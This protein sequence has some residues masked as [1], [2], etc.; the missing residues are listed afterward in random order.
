[1][2]HDSFVYDLYDLYGF[3]LSNGNEGR[4]LQKAID[5]TVIAHYGNKESNGL[6]G[7]SFFF[8]LNNSESKQYSVQTYKEIAAHGYLNNYY[9]FLVSYVKNV[10]GI[11]G[12]SLPPLTKKVLGAEN[13][14]NEP[15][16]VVTKNVPVSNAIQLAK[17]G[18][19]FEVSLDS[20]L[21]NSFVRSYYLILRKASQNIYYLVEQGH[22]L[23]LSEKGVLSVTLED[24][25][26]VISGE[27]GKTQILP[28]VESE[29][30]Q[31][32]L[33]GGTRLLRRR[34]S[35]VKLLT[36]RIIHNTD[37]PSGFIA[38]LSPFDY[39]PMVMK[40]E[41]TIEP[42]D[43]LTPVYQVRIITMDANGEPLPFFF[44]KEENSGIAYGREFIVGN[45]GPRISFIPCG[46]DE[47]YYVQICVEDVN[48]VTYATSL[49][50]LNKKED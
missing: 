11:S 48:G 24:H 44:W 23:E 3:A 16:V 13:Q 29:R 33:K 6:N 10:R 12:K 14:H 49:A 26:R 37:K 19:R 34:A 31:N 43:C 4:Q 36:G 30:G 40:T 41:E 1:M 35:N 27:D 28:F 2:D 18:L 5:K 25:I 9:Q 15:S 17:K 32:Y 20:E 8:P 47:E 45:G 46:T 22:G 38:S 7:L 21:I 50:P 42:E 39:S